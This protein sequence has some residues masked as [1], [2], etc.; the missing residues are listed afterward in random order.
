MHMIYQQKM[1][2]QLKPQTLI[3]C[4]QITPD[5]DADPPVFLTPQE[6]F[7]KFGIKL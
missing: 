6:A 7:H 1:P 2:G 4:C 3:C 5:R